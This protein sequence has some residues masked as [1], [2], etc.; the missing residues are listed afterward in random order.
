MPEDDPEQGPC[1]RNCSL[2]STGGEELT[3]VLCCVL[4]MDTTVETTMATE[5]KCLLNV[6][7]REVASL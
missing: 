6:W 7:L 5:P 3:D 4:S 2:R 1:G